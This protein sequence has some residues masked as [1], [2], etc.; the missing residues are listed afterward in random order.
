MGGYLLAHAHHLNFYTDAME[1]EEVDPPARL[2][3]GW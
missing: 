2:S 1:A 3:G